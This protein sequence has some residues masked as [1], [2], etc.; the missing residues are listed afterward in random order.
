MANRRVRRSEEKSKSGQES[1]D[2]AYSVDLKHDDDAHAHAHA[3][4]DALELRCL[5]PLR[6]TQLDR[7][8]VAWP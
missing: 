1:Q 3:H 5:L 6:Q 4:D 7:H 8:T 2:S